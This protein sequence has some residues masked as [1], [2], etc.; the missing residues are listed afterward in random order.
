M[1]TLLRRF[2]DR[3]RIVGELARFLASRRLWWFV[4][5]FLLLLIFTGLLVFAEATALGPF[6]YALF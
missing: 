6:I 4:P 5:L 3:V 1:P 2:A